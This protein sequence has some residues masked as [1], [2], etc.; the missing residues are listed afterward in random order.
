VSA[1]DYL[2]WFVFSV[3]CA[4]ASGQI[5]IAAERHGV[6]AQAWL[7]A[8]AFGLWSTLAAVCFWGVV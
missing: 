5:F 1:A 8:T 3:F 4:F 6:H 2:I 7:S